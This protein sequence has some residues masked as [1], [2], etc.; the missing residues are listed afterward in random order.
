VRLL[1]VVDPHTMHIVVVRMA[2]VGSGEKGWLG[3]V[4][5]GYVWLEGKEGLVRT[6][7][8]CT[9][10]NCSAGVTHLVGLPK[11]GSPL[12]YPLASIKWWPTS[13]VGGE[14]PVVSVSMSCGVR[15]DDGSYREEGDTKDRA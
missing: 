8:S 13:L 1:A 15:R 3:W 9:G 6:L 10:T 5:L 12:L 4:V 14:R 11:H 7:A 2:A